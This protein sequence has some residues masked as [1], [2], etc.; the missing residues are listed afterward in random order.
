VGFL[1]PRADAAGLRFFRPFGPGKL[2]PSLNLAWRETITKNIEVLAI[3][4]SVV[5]KYL[6]LELVL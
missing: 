1:L 6:R 5:F 3:L 2:E 4:D